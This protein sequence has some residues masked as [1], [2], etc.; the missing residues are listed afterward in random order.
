MDVKP[1]LKV[2]VFD[3]DG[4]LFDLPLDWQTLRADLGIKDSDKKIGDLLQEYVEQNHP[5]LQK[6]TT[7][8]IKAVGNH[9][10]SEL[11]EQALCVLAT[12]YKLAVFTR[13]SRLA[14]EKS[15]EGTMSK[16]IYIVGREDVLQQKPYPEGLHKI[17]HHYRAKPGESMLV[18]DTYHDI[19]A[20]RAADMKVAIVYNQNLQY[21]PEGA[22][23]Y[24][25]SVAELPAVLK[26]IY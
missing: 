4:T 21:Q 6:V 25:P 12:Q 13:N 15:L 11:I 18:G 19:E 2:V 8:E 9:R 7:S 16:D 17:L 26:A 3:F 22:D 1:R 24:I 20:A 10:I 23:A 5:D 14:V